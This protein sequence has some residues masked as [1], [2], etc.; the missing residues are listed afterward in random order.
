[1]TSRSPSDLRHRSRQYRHRLAAVPRRPGAGARHGPE[2][3]PAGAVAGEGFKRGFVV[4]TFSPKFFGGA[5]EFAGTS[6]HLSNAIKDVYAQY[7]AEQGQSPRRASGRGLHRL[8]SDEGPLRHQL[9]AD[10]SR[11]CSGSSGRKICRT[12]ARSTPPISGTAPAAARPPRPRRPH[13]TCRRRHRHP[14]RLPPTRSAK[15]CSE[16]TSG[17]LRPSGLLLRTA[18]H[19]SMTN[20]QP[21]IEPDRGTDA[22]TCRRICSRAGSTA[23]MTGESNWPGPTR[24]TA[25]SST[26]PSLA[27]TSSTSWS[28]VPWP[29]TASPGRTSIS[30]RRCANRI[31]RHSAVAR[32]TNSLR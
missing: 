5:A 2:H 1:M 25:S 10:A 31:S 21:M 26:P 27:P 20:V 12:R 28:S 16:R 17:G 9:P 8:G 23:A 13:S 3:R 22:P 30:A 18:C 24:A 14:S 19:V 11:S 32:T 15:R 7:E 4:M 29:K 6:V